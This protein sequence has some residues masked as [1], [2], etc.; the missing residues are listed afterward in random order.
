MKEKFIPK[1]LKTFPGPVSPVIKY[2]NIA[3]ISGQISVDPKK[4]DIIKGDIKEETKNALNNMKI[5]LE[6]MGLTLDSVLKCDVFLNDIN[7]FDE[8]NEIYREFF[9]TECPPA[10]T[11][12]SVDLWGEMKVE[13][14]AVVGL[15]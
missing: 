14:S 2:G 3:F 12:L 4:G 9:G 5:I 8:M 13:I 1:N 7:D 6:D 15:N 11:A 10:R